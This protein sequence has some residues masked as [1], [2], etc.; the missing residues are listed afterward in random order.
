M[1]HKDL[2]A[3]FMSMKEKK[4]SLEKQKMSLGVKVDS[5]ESSLKSSMDKLEE[6]YQVSSL[7]EAKALLDK[8]KKE[9]ES[10]L[11]SAEDKLKG[12]EDLL[13]E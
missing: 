2:V 4:E 6:K 9:I 12:Y 1:E 8:T 13:N 5:L 3:R 10:T 11:E 7:Q